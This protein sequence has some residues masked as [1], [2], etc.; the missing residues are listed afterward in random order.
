MTDENLEELIDAASDL[1]KPVEEIADTIRLAATNET[2]EDCLANLKE[3]RAQ[4]QRL[5]KEL[6]SLIKTKRQEE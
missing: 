5:I 2:E 3:A 1:E 4:A 6:D